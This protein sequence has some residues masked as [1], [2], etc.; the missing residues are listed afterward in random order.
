MINKGLFTTYAPDLETLDGGST[1]WEGVLFLQNEYDED[2]YQL[3]KGLDNQHAIMVDVTSGKITS[4]SEDVSMM[5]PVDSSLYFITVEEYIHIN[6]N[7]VHNVTV[8]D[9]IVVLKTDV[10]LLLEAKGVVEG[11]INI[12]MKSKLTMFNK[13]FITSFS[14]LSS[15][16]SFS[17]I[18]TYPYYI[19]CGQVFNWGVE[20]FTIIRNLQANVLATEVVSFETIEVALPVFP[21]EV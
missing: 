2:F 21:F 17:K 7:G 6:N 19:E 8:V 10:E 13:T 11:Q 5:F 16:E 4:I 18:T 14:S 3:I 9:G 12:F 1:N 20:C 15:F